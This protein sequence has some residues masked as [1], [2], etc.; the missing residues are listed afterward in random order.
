MI[1]NIWAEFPTDKN[2]TF[3]IGDSSY[4][5]QMAKTAGCFAI[6]VTWGNFPEEGL[7]NAG[8]DICVHSYDDLI[9]SINQLKSTVKSC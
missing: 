4:D 2:D 1:Q 7:I 5:M 9:P 8:A 6:G 3:M